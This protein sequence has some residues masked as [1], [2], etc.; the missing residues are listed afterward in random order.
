MLKSSEP[1]RFIAAGVF[2]MVL[3]FVLAYVAASAGIA[4]FAASAGA[5]AVCFVTIYL[6]HRNWTFARDVPH[7]RALPRYLAVQLLCALASGLLAHGLVYI[8]G[9]QPFAMSAM[10]AIAASAFSY[11]ATSLWAFAQQ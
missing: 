3:F 5:Y 7:G 4:P 11:F 6:V 2:G 8:F 9:F 1:L 10:T